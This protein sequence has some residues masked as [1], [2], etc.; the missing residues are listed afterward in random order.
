M[1]FYLL[2]LFYY[3]LVPNY[4]I[5]L[6]SL[7]VS[8]WPLLDHSRLWRAIWERWGPLLRHNIICWPRL[9]E[10]TELPHYSPRGIHQPSP[11]PEQPL[12]IFVRGWIQILPL[13]TNTSHNMGLY[14]FLSIQLIW[15]QMEFH[16]QFPRKPMSPPMMIQLNSWIHLN[17]WTPL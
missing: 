14:T 4:Q 15:S 2:T 5:A 16:P 1:N 11:F 7:L 6:Y 9:V 10:F 3:L 13:T 17:H 12:H 8:L